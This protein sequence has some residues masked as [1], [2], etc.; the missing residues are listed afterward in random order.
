MKNNTKTI[1]A[2]I[3]FLIIAGGVYFVSQKQ[4]SYLPQ[5]TETN[6]AGIVDEDN[7]A[8]VAENSLVA[9]SSNTQKNP[10]KVVS[11]NKSVQTPTPLSQN[12]LKYKGEFFPFEFLYPTSFRIVRK[13]TP[14][15]AERESESYNF[16]RL[17]VDGGIAGY[18]SFYVN[19]D[20]DE[21]YKDLVA[22]YPDKY[23]VT[24]INDY[25]F[26]KH[27]EKDTSSNNALRIEYITF[28]N[29]TKYRFSLVVVNGDKKDL[30][31]KT[32]Q[33]EFDMMENIVKS[34][35]IN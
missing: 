30:D 26:Y 1:I 12:L 2:V 7:T 5:T 3:V 13:T 9:T 21:M 11:E 28:K 31:L 18:V 24:K 19:A 4:L 32:Y 33:S 29:G 35:K 23:S 34:L 14:N 25:T 17:A 22:T 27:V 6:E 10:A 16:N 15:T 20:N 8:I